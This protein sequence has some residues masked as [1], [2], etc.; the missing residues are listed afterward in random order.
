MARRKAS[1]KQSTRKTAH[2]AKFP[3]D[4]V[5]PELIHMVFTYLKP[6][7]ASTFRWAGK[8]VAQIGLQYL[9]PTVCLKLNKESYD[10]LVAIARHP[11]VSKHVTNLEY[12]TGGLEPITRENL[13]HLLVTTPVI[14]TRRSDSERPGPSA[15]ARAWR[16]YE[17]QPICE[18]PVLS[19]T[20]KVRRFNRAGSLYDAYQTSQK[21]V[22]QADFYRE[23]IIE[24]MRRFRNLRTI[25]TPTKTSYERYVA[26]IREF[27]PTCY[28]RGE[29][30]SE[31]SASVC[32]TGSMLLAVDVA[33]LQ[34]C[35]LNAQQVGW[36]IL[37]Q[38]RSNFAA[39]KRSIAGLQTMN[40][41]FT[42][43]QGALRLGETR[44]WELTKIYYLKTGRMADFV[45][46]TPNLESLGLSFRMWPQEIAFPNLNTVI[47]NVYWPRLRV[48][49][50]DT[51]ASVQFNLVEFCERHAHT[52]KDLSLSNMHLLDLD[53]R[54]DFLYGIRRAFRFG[55]QLDTCKLGGL[56][57]DRSGYRDLE[58]DVDRD[59]NLDPHLTFGML[60]S[61]YIQTT[62][63]GDVTFEGFLQG[64]L[65]LA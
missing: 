52:L 54:T 32:A 53:F 12:E 51:I 34:L 38:N 41:A 26:E 35:S 47:G 4:T 18:I 64:V 60:F 46:S 9:A 50:L 2:K 6:T 23:K 3:A 40:L 61:N 49:E 33:G 30:A 24:A 63:F 57:R 22:E 42:N 44:F 65:L 28:F 25:S 13:D 1:R 11:E 37:S 27:L 8:L 59:V 45:G 36:R 10:R 56:F 55:Q 58:S 19:N 48:L 20:Q 17:R 39:L 16:A 62:R 5:P 15:S 21:N 7:E 29:I 43:P 31:V 14:F